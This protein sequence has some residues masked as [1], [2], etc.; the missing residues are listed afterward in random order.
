MDS[1]AIRDYALSLDPADVAGTV[2]ALPVANPTAF[3]NKQRGTGIRH[4]GTDDL[5]S[6][7]P[8]DDAGSFSQRLAATI[9]SLVCSHADYVVN[10][11][12]ADGETV[13]H[14]GFAYVPITGEERPVDGET[15][16]L[17]N[18]SGV[19]YL[20]KLEVSEI[21]GF[22][23]GE[24]VT[25]VIPGIIVE[26][27]GGAQVYDWAYETYQQSFQNVARHLGVLSGE[28]ERPPDS[29]VSTDLGFLFASVGGFVETSVRG[30]DSVTEGH[31]VAEMTSSWS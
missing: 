8:G 20:V 30:G 17:G 25:E 26:A 28:P 9:F 3:A 19:S 15:R 21:P 10:A 29:T 18:I 13:M 2:V 14:T 5:N 23:T 4:I 12:S 7:F 24:L 6:V 27:G 16:E 22:M 1:L 11:H 31:R